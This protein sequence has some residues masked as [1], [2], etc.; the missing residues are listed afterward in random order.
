MEDRRT[1]MGLGNAPKEEPD[2]SLR[3]L[4]ES[5]PDSV[6]ETMLPQGDATAVIRADCLKKVVD[7]LKNDPRLQFDVLVDITAV[8]YLERIPRFDVVYHFVSL[9]FN[10]RLRLKVRV[11]DGVAV[12]DSLTPL[13]GSANWLER[14]VWDMFGIRF[15]GHPNLQRILMYEGFEGHPLRKDYPIRKR[16]PLIGPKN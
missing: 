10:R 11:D 14:E 1:G 15:E 3:L 9:P 4:S 13:W 7:F 12:L 2:F 16:Q 5:L 6:L 8:D